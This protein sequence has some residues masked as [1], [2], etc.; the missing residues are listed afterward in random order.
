VGVSKHSAGTGPAASTYNTT[1]CICLDRD[2]EAVTSWCQIYMR[3]AEQLEDFNRLS[4][5]HSNYG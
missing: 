4:S 3:I 1:H 2:S 5:T